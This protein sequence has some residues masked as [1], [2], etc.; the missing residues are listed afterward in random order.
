MNEKVVVYS[1]KTMLKITGIKVKGLRPPDLEAKLQEVFDRPVRLIGVTGSK[2]EMD[3][4]NLDTD[5]IIKKTD[6]L[7]SAISF[8][9][10]ITANNIIEITSSDRIVEVSIEEA[11]KRAKTPGQCGRERWVTSQHEEAQQNKDAQAR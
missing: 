5:S 7:A 10:G 4:Y 6:D 2:I 11:S 1:D 8:V 9:E 3:I